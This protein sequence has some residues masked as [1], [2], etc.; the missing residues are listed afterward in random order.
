[1][2]VRLDFDILV[3]FEFW[4]APRSERDSNEAR[5]TTDCLFK[6]RLGVTG[7]DMRRKGSWRVTGDETGGDIETLSA[8]VEGNKS[9]D[10]DDIAWRDA[11]GRVNKS[12][13]L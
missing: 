3:G 6:L 9:R 10:G 12:T 7:R 5:L 8:S 13:R 11:L 4:D 2:E 1:M